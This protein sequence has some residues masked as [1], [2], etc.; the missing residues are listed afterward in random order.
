MS[1]SKF[2]STYCAAS[3]DIVG[4]KAMLP[5]IFW[6]LD[7]SATVAGGILASMVVFYLSFGAYVRIRRLGYFAPTAAF[8]V[9]G[10]D[11]AVIIGLGVLLQVTLPDTHRDFIVGSVTFFAFCSVTVVAFATAVL[12]RMLP[13]RRDSTR[14]FGPR[15][16][17]F[18]FISLGRLIIA[19]S[20]AGGFISL[21]W[22]MIA[23]GATMLTMQAAVLTII[24]MS[25][26]VFGG[27]RLIVYGRSIRDPETIEGALKSDVRLPVLYLRP[28]VSEGLSFVVRAAGSRRSARM[29]PGVRFDDHLGPTIR[30]RIGPFVALGNPQDYLPHVEGATRTY[31]DD[32]GWYKHFERLA[33]RAACIVMQVSDSNNLKQELTFI[34]REGLQHRLFIFTN[35]MKLKSVPPLFR[36]LIGLEWISSRLYGPL[37]ANGGL[38]TWEQ[39]AENLGKLGFQLGNDPGRGAVVTFDSEGNAVVLVKGAEGLS[40]REY[41][42]DWPPSGFV[43]PIRQYLVK[44]LGLDLSAGAVNAESHQPTALPSEKCANSWLGPT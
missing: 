29:D 14:A 26:W 17:R 10:V 33:G 19:I 37:P 24:T 2:Q 38:A 31:A 36:L 15:R 35:T 30:E 21:G 18:P 27:Y 6:L 16:V 41:D 40:K 42:C 44:T 39:F 5:A 28:F 1:C 12:V 4:G 3:V 23:K 20:I 9:L 13:K 32:E 8:L 7:I 22:L 25:C 34:R 11:A 43:E